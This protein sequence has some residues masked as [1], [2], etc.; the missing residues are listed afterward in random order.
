MSKKRRIPDGGTDRTRSER[1][2]SASGARGVTAES[3]DM[4]TRSL[5]DRTARRRPG[6]LCLRSLSPADIDTIAIYGSAQRFGDRSR[7]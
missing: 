5:R 6:D 2:R 7:R 3:V 1:A 4:T